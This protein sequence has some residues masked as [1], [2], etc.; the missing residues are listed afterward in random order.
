MYEII[1]FACKELLDLS[2][3]KRKSNLMTTW[4]ERRFLTISVI[5]HKSHSPMKIHIMEDDDKNN[6]STYST[7]K[8]KKHDLSINR[9]IGDF[10][11]SSD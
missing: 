2:T 3:V 11:T 4:N 8:I 9:R 1:H 5:P 7:T 10:R 6:E